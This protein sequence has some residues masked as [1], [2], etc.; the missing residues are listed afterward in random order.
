MSGTDDWSDFASLTDCD[1]L[2]PSE[3]EDDLLSS[4]VG[5]SVLDALASAAIREAPEWEVHDMPM[6]A[7]VVAPTMVK[8]TSPPA[9]VAQS[10]AADARAEELDRGQSR[11]WTFTAN[12][13]SVR[14]DEAAFR[15]HFAHL[16]Y[17]VF[18]HEVGEEG[19][20][21]LQGYLQLAKKARWSAVAN[22]LEKMCGKRVRVVQ[23]N[24]S[25]KDNEA[26][27]TKDETRVDGPWRFGERKPC[28]GRK[29]G[30]NDLLAFT[31]ALDSDASLRDVAAEHPASFLRYHRGAREYRA[32]RASK[33]DWI[34]HIE[35]HI[36][37]SG[38]G[39]SRAARAA[40]PDAYWCEDGNWWDG[41]DGEATVILDEFSGS[42]I[43]IKRLLRLLDSSPLRMP[44]KGGFVQMVARNYIIT[45][46][47]EPEDWY[48]YEKL[49]Y[50][51]WEKRAEHPETGVEQ[52]ANPVRR[53][54]EEWGTQIRYG[55]VE[56]RP[57][58][59]LGAQYGYGLPQ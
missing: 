32:L 50:A 46:N 33:R 34:P 57:A 23:A 56:R 48:A 11:Y 15:K 39:K 29:G 51:A 36:G 18:Q 16:Q 4:C 26:Y 8:T 55:A 13:F 22:K 53:R 9:P 28:S 58:V 27:C 10:E 19:T 47:F 2:H 49:G 35:V 44:Y 45:S 3:D 54:L 25:D 14:P 31:R 12:N 21:H 6:S 20:P 30:R 1:V 38:V 5:P 43:P 24:G 52:W 59:D 40:Y 37:P 17:V 7:D 42:F 41:Y